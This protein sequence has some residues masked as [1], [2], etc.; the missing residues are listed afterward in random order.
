MSPVNTATE[1]KPGATATQPGPV[2]K[3]PA[4]RFKVEPLAASSDAMAPRTRYW[5]GTVPGC[6]I[7]NVTAGGQVFPLFSGTPVFGADGKP[8]RPLTLGTYNDLTAS[9]VEAVC[10]GIKMRVLRWIGADKKRGVILLRD[11]KTYRAEP[12]DEPLAKWVYMTTDER[13]ESLPP[14]MLEE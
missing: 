6:P 12:G 3:S 10:A 2:A 1:P 5:M 8:D 11:S 7:Q 14:P 9:Q 4:I 13:R